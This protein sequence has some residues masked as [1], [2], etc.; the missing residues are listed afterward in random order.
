MSTQPNYQLAQPPKKG[1]ALAS[2]II[3]IVSIFTCG[4]FAVGAIVGSVLG[5]IALNN[6]KANPTRYGGKGLAIAGII[7]SVFSLIPGLIAAIAIPNLLTAQQAARETAAIQEI[8][9]IGTAQLTYSVTSGRGKFAD[10][11][12]LG[13][14][15]LIDKSLASG[16]KGGYR[17]EVQAMYEA[18][19]PAM[20]DV[21]A[22]PLQTGPFG[23]G[24][25]SFYSNETMSIFESEG[26]EPPSA[27][28]GDRI[29]KN[30]T[31][32]E[33]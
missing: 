8:K 12:T 7:T 16:E 28:V 21:T 17:F 4:L 26:G 5:I 13:D 15:G 31:L 1:L 6:A 2:L 25:R 24:N 27:S 23:T 22:R 14:R 29:P 18:G 30:G 10:L 19:E 9:S 32:V 20:F 11:R 33:Q 3:G